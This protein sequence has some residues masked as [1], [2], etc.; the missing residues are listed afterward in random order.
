M[1]LTRHAVAR[2][3]RAVL[4]L[5][6]LL[7]SLAT[8]AQP[9]A[10]VPD[11]PTGLSASGAPIPTLSWTRNPT[12]TRYRVQGAE[13]ATFSTVVFDQETVNDRYTPTRVLRAGTL[14]WRVLAVDQTGSSAW[15]RAEAPVTALKVPTGVQVSSA[16]NQILPPVSPPI[17][18][19]EGVPGAVSYDV[20]MD[21]EGDNV[22]GILREDIRSTTYVWPDPQGVG[23]RE[24]FEDFY[25]RVRARFEN[26]MQSAWSGWTSYNVSQLPPVTSQ[27]CATGL[28]CAPNATTG[29]VQP[30]TTVQD[31]VLAWDPIK[32]AKQYEIWV[33][34]DA[35]FN[36]QIEKRTVYSTRYSPT[37]TWDNNTYYWKVRAINAEGQPTPW[38]VAPS[39]FQRRWPLQPTLLY[40]P[41]QSQAPVVNGDLY[42]QWTPVKHASRYV[43]ELS[44][45]NFASSPSQSCQTSSTTFVTGDDRNLGCIPAQG[46]TVY[47]RVRALDNPRGV[48]G[49][50]SQT[51]RFVYDSGQVQP[52]APADGATVSVPTLRW[53]PSQDANRYYVEVTSAYGSASI[54]T[55]ALSWTPTE[56]L[57]SDSDTQD[58]DRL[59]DYFTWKIHAIDGDGRRSP[60]YGAGSFYL[61]ESQTA[62]ASP[63]TPIAQIP[64]QISS[65]FPVLAWQPMASQQ[66]AR[67]Q[68]QLRI[69]ET[70][71]Y[72]VSPDA[73]EVLNRRVAYSSVTDWD[74]YFLRPGTYTWWVEAYDA[75]DGT[76]I[77]TGTPATFT[78]APPAETTGEQV[79]LDGLAVDAG[80]TC[81]KRLVVGQEQTVCGGLSATPVLDWD[82]TP[83]AGGYQVYVAE[84]ADFT[85]LVYDGVQTINSRFTP[86]SNSGPSQLPDNESGPA[87]YWYVRPCAMVM[88]TR[89]CGPA[90]SGTLDAGTGAFRKIS[91]KVQLQ[92]PANNATFADQVTFTWADYNTTNQSTAPIY[93][94]TR[95]PYQTA[96]RY[97]I[98][99]AQ[100]ATITDSNK[101]DEQEVDQA[102]YTAF[103]RTYPEG[104][105]WWRVQAIDDAGNRLAWSD[106]RRLLKATPASKLDATSTA[107]PAFD[108]H[109]DAGTTLF[110]WAAGDFDSSWDIEVYRNDDTTLSAGNRVLSRQVSQAAYSMPDLLAP[111]AQAYRWRVRR[112]DVAGQPGRWSDLGRFFVDPVT[113][114]LSVP[115]QGATM[116]PN[117]GVLTWDA[118]A[119][120]TRAARYVL[121]VENVT[122]GGSPGSVTTYATTY[123]LPNTLET[124]TYAWTVRAYDGQ[125]NYLGSSVERRFV[126][127]AGLRALTAVQIQAPTGSA[128]GQTL[129]STAPTWNQPDVTMSY[130]WLR[131]GSDIGNATG[132][133]YTLTTADYTRVVTLRVTA[134]KP[135]Y[136]EGR[137]TSNALSITAGGALQGTGQ[138][139]ISGTA[140]VGSSLQVTTGSWSPGATDYRYQWL[141]QGAPIPDAKGSSYSL[142]AADA[143]K[144]V[145]VTVFASAQ[146][147]AEGALTT[148]AVSVARMKSSVTGALQADQV[149]VKKRAKLGITVSVPDLPNPTGAVQVLDKG[150]KIAQITLAPARNGSQTIK[151][152][153]LKKGKHKLQVVYLG[154]AQ[155][156]G[157]K[158]KKIVLYIIK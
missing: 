113:V 135:S 25:V 40:P 13:D 20:E 92:S 155:V 95:P 115:A 55:S 99:V 78:I 74:S 59:P 87:Y 57:P 42:Y 75:E 24:G 44:N 1:S 154:N 82:P 17:I 96:N 142:R 49:V 119:G 22:G 124:G 60:T 41:V 141:R 65:R 10:A 12:V 123:A 83:G 126:V 46:T 111:S 67:V 129:T 81:A 31:V 100:S 130:Q 26:N 5:A 45:D 58:P 11:A 116:E 147:F 122:G 53:A 7:A 64:G 143:G 50:Y 121:N 4:V 103:G 62:G 8:F 38:P 148:A 91:P 77:G 88:P 23:E 108:S 118:L 66:D 29:Q 138:P 47:W 37:T 157:S 28:V 145:S 144:D 18:R 61:R 86:H 3:A 21:A 84:D 133:T 52:L 33:A 136:V 109:I 112:T 151:L 63:L 80:N 149:K 114:A 152:P 72:V 69:S 137:T 6:M 134:R 34:L 104:D 19:W 105:L 94:G 98:Q 73:T 90:P 158:S 131:D 89:N 150:K 127:D 71:P 76:K 102:T 110:R 27:S 93:G 107:A 97:R 79:A 36:T 2:H 14:Y 146:G 128:V 140:S 125:G 117:A 56:I 48:N 51:G 35:D 16:G 32:G 30:S 120:T 43:L 101:I 54:T 15:A 70:P 68:Y 9:A 39:V 139:T 132:P 153:K 106:T 85:N 156:F